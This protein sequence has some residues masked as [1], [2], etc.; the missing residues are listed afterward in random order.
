MK[1]KGW[2][3]YTRTLI[4]GLGPALILS[5]VLSG[6]FI[7]VRIQ[8]VKHELD[9]KGQLIALQ[10]ASTSDYFVLTGN[11]SIISPLTRVL[12]ED[13][14]VEFIEIE[15]IAGGVLF[16]QSDVKFDANPI[17]EDKGLLRWYQADIIQYDVLADDDEWFTQEKEEKVLGQVRVGLSTHFVEQR[18]NGIILN[19]FIIAGVAMGL[20]GLIAWLS[21]ARL[22]TPISKL[23]SIVERMAQ[24]DYSARTTETASGEVKQLQEGV[25]TLAKELERSEEVQQHYVDSLIKEREASEQA[26]KAKSEFLA[27]MTHELRTP[28]NGVL[29]MLQLMQST[30]LSKEQEEYV[31]I[32]MS[33]GDHLLELINDILDFSK[34]EQGNIELD[35]K[36][37]DLYASLNRVID[38]FK[39]IVTQKDLQFKVDISAVKNLRVKGDETRLHQVLVNLLGNAVKFTNRGHVGLGIGNVEKIN[40]QIKFSLVVSDSGKGISEENLQRIFDAFQQE[41]ASISRQYGGTGLGLAISKQ[42]VEKM[43]GEL[44]V[45]SA[46]DQGS[47]FICQFTWDLDVLEKTNTLEPIK[48]VECETFQSRVLLVEDNVV[49]QKVALKMLA[50]FGLNCD[51][52]ADGVQALHLTRQNQYD[53]ILMDLQMPNMDGYQATKA[54]RSEEG[55]NKITP[56]VALTANALY[57]V[58]N[59][60]LQ[61]GMNDFLAKPYKKALLQHL[62]V[63]WL[64]V[65]P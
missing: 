10:L 50:D 28:M 31:D 40:D 46:A 52:A 43:N 29:G 13:K 27:V 65:R 9:N 36:F 11:Q 58:K 26:N 12:L 34:I 2:S 45:Q 37:F 19:A 54:I 6:Y 18:Q 30:D 64:K 63:R 56:I 35:Q 39:S 17:G 41:D 55:L 44:I 32:A 51:L 14:D 20:C 7:N 8:D 24:G 5:I 60:C 33:S 53:L 47:R 22:V 48:E 38:E 4:L 1:N 42:L 49:N 3:L 57:D 21:G 25:N 23:S 61:A 15:D 62:L 16:S 59:Q